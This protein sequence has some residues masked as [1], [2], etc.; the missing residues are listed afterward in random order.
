VTLA[1]T[2]LFVI[3]VLV[4]VLIT[5]GVQLHAKHLTHRRTQS[6]IRSESRKHRAKPL[7]VGGRVWYSVAAD[8]GAAASIIHRDELARVATPVAN[9]R[10]STQ[11]S[12]ERSH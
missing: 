7:E 10:G 4:V 9:E 1:G 8:S 5:T 12:P 11:A 2:I 3:V 6:P